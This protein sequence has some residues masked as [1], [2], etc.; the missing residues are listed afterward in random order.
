MAPLGDGSNQRGQAPALQIQ[1]CRRQFGLHRH[2]HLGRRGR[3]RG[4]AV[5]GV[6]DQRGIRLMPDGGDQRDRAGRHGTYHRLLV[7][8]HQVFQATAAAGDDQHVR[9]GHRTA[10]RQRVE[11]G[12]RLGDL[13]GRAVALHRDRP[14]QDVA[15]EAIRQPV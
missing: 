4:A 5:G 3:R 1:Q 14:Q 2:G 15:R 9:P 13:P 12:D 7:E 8:R 11:P 6:V 10:R